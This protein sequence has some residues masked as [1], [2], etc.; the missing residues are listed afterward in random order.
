M[1]EFEKSIKAHLDNRA[2]G[3]EPFAEKYNEGLAGKKSIAAC[4]NYII[5]EVKKTGR[6]GFTDDE[7]FGMAVHFYD[8]KKIAAP[9]KNTHCKV[10]VNKEVKLTAAEIKKIQEEA[11]REAEEKVRKEE[12]ARIDKERKAAAERARKAEER[13]KAEDV[14]KKEEAKR[15]AEKEGSL[16]LFSLFE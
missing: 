2:K 1:N 11:R 5:S 12:L 4:C 6:S 14:R 8:E 16:F 15:R 10:V 7:I 13:R 3:D 9:S